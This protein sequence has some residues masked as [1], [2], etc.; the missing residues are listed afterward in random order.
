MPQEEPY[1][2]DI[3]PDSVKLQ[4]RSADLPTHIMDYSPITYRL[5]AQEMP[6]GEWITVARGIP[7]TD[8]K[9]T[10]LHPLRD[11]SFRVRAENDY[12]VSDPTRPVAVQKR[13]GTF[14]SLPS[15]KFL[16]WS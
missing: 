4:W 11:Y 10:G 14:N 16:D 2:V 12:G 1:C 15:N 6:S 8:F 9:V 13:A 5:E 3:N 7:H